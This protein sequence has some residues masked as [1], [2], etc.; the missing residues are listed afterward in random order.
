MNDMGMQITETAACGAPF[1]VVARGSDAF[2]IELE[3][4]PDPPAR[5]FVRGSLEP[6]DRIAIVGSRSADAASRRFAADL[7]GDLATAGM[8]IVSGGA[9]GID[10]AAH[11][12]ALAAG[13]STAAVLGSGFDHIY[14]EANRDLFDRIARRGAVLT[15]LS[16]EQPPTRWTFPKRN[17]IV[18]ALSS[19]VVIVQAGERSGALITAGI[20]RELGVPVG[21]VPQAAGDPAGRGC[22]QLLRTG[23]AIVENARDVLALLKGARPPEQLVLGGLGRGPRSSLPSP[24]STLTAQESKILDVLG[25]RP[26]HIDDIAA[27]TG[28]GSGETGAALLS[29][30]IAGLVEDQGGKNYVRVG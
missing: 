15:E 26:Q 7:A 24:P 19:A 4:L 25:A 5:L 17:R 1:C 14:P 16:P 3:R 21:A 10:T 6:V 28:L 2:P 23:A 27:G 11:E 18:A 9:L 22:N 13:G 30:E 29:L 20:A 8:A 12:G